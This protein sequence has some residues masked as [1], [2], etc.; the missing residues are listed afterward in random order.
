MMIFRRFGRR[1][2]PAADDRGFSLVEIMVGAT[3]MSI[4]TAIAAAGF[5]QMYQAA[6]KADTSGQAQA[7][8]SSAFA[9]LDAEVR[10]AYRINAAYQIGTTSYAVDYLVKNG[11]EL[12]CVQL[13]LPIGGGALVR[14]QWLQTATSADP[15]AVSTGIADDLVTATAEVNPFTVKAAGI[16]QS[17]YDRL[18]MNVNGR[19]G[20]GNGGSV[21]NY[22]LQFTALN[23]TVDD[24]S[25]H[26]LCT[27]A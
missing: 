4:V 23:T 17:N 2:C 24:P 9:K 14:R 20:V 19:V 12:Q 7:A 22:H 1:P 25:L 26:T 16:E 18:V 21:R 3:I 13:T 10:Y 6:E 27:K 5:M 8:L 11:T 15:G